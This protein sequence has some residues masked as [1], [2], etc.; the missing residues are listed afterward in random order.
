MAFEK[1]PLG[2]P[3]RVKGKEADPGGALENSTCKG[4]AGL[5]NSLHSPL[6][7]ALLP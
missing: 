4:R 5:T 6:P 7:K 3:T 1:I 2:L